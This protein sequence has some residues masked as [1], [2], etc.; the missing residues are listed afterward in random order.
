[1]RS[2][3][4][5]AGL[6]LGCAGTGGEVDGTQTGG[7]SSSGASGTD[8]DPSEA[9]TDVSGSVLLLDAPDAVSAGSLLYVSVDAPLNRITVRLGGEALEPETFLMTD[10]PTGLF[11]VPSDAALGEST[12]SAQLRDDPRITDSRPIQ[13]WAPM[14]EDVAPRLGLDVR[15]DATGSPPECAESH[16]GVAWGDY[17]ADGILDVY[18][19][20]VGRAG[21]LHRGSGAGADLGFEEVTEAVGLAGVDS[22][23]MATFVDLE[24]DG[25]QDL[26]VGRRGD[27]RMF[28]NLLAE[29]GEARFEDVSEATG[30]VVDSQRTM[31]A[32]FGDFDGD[33]D[34]DLYEVNHAFCFPQMGSEV[35]ARDHLFENVDGRF[36]ERPWMD[37]PILDSVAFSAAWLDT[38]RD[39]DLDLVVINDDVGGL[40]GYPNAHWRNDG[41]GEQGWRFAE[42]SEQTGLSLPG[43]NGMGLAYGDLDDDGFVDLAFSNIGA[44]HLL[45]SNG[46]GTWTDVDAGLGR[47]QLPWGRN[48][49]TWAVHLLDLDNDGDLDFYASG[50]RIKGQ[51][52]VV[53]AVFD[54]E[55]SQR[56]VERTWTSGAADPA[57]GKASAHVDFDRDG[58]LDIVTTAW[59][60]PARVYRNV[61][62]SGHHWISIA[63]AQPGPNA[64]ALGAIV[65]LQAGGRRRTCFHSQRPSLGS[66]SQLECHFG[67]GATDTI[68]GLRVRWPDG[69]EQDIEP[70]AVDR[71][72]R[73]ER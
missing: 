26:Y 62:A 58:A 54:N 1:M 55:G 64:D 2:P 24:G 60:A 34:L 39:G 22:V 36:V 45:L 56:F 52:P 15:H 73:I 43:V 49:I 19:G 42:V 33:G 11:R 38:D 66:G 6:L 8:T 16:T 18:F 3:L 63:L 59:D 69:T 70:P 51:I 17:D 57:H 40:I 48:S 20:N 71:Y 23:S 12:L 28:R 21:T 53:D 29:S 37:A 30:V 9:D 5:V 13:V 4:L 72:L 10:V 14:L 41:P 46:D 67:L 61:H 27:N 44:N 68:D 65:T 32:A 25:D 50:G 35:R 31:G 7:A 47:G